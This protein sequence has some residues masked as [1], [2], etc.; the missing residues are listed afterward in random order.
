M[1]DKTEMCFCKTCGVETLHFEVLVRKPS[2]FENS[3]NRKR[4]E[5]FAGFFKSFF[6]G[7]FLASMDEFSRHLICERCGTKIIEE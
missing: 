3:K 1:S 4:K 7:A 5:F 2:D 6:V